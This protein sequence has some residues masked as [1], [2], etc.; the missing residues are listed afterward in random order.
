[1]FKCF[2]TGRTSIDDVEQCG[3][4]STS[5]TELLIAQVGNVICGNCGLPLREVAE[6]VGISIGS[7]HVILT[8]DLGMYWVSAKFGIFF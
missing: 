4:A 1:L 7:C 3:Q 2:K 5:T 8:E 6:E